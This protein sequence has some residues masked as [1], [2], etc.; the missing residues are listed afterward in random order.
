[1]EIMRKNLCISLALLLLFV[2]GTYSFGA[3]ANSPIVSPINSPIVSPINSPIVSPTATGTDIYGRYSQRGLNRDLF[4]TQNPRRFVPYNSLDNVNGRNGLNRLR[5]ILQRSTASYYSLSP[6]TAAL[7]S[8]DLTALGQTQLPLPGQLPNDPS[9]LDLNPQRP[10]SSQLTDIDMSLSR[11]MKLLELRDLYGDLPLEAGILNEPVRKANPDITDLLQ[12]RRPAE[13]ATPQLPGEPFKQ[14]K[15]LDDIKDGDVYDSLF[16]E[17]ERD[18]SAKQLEEKPGESKYGIKVPKIKPLP[19][20]DHKKAARIRGKHKTFDSLARAKTEDYIKIAN[21]MLTAGKSYKAADA[22]TLAI[23]WRPENAEAHLIKGLALFAAGEYMSAS[24][25]IQQAIELN[26][27]YASEKIGLEEKI[28][29]IDLI[30]NRLVEAKQWQRQARSPEIAF[31]IAF[32]NY[33]QGNVI[34][35]LEIIEKAV[36][37]MGDNAAVKALHEV[38][39]AAD[40]Y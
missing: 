37:K 31:L 25:F 12:K 28:P 17:M 10:M 3:P 39:K 5:S 4:R 30:D 40:K 21:K 7:R 24:F 33:Q 38:I 19:E 20:A 32:I 1:M 6:A 35:A 2:I 22:C 26:K 27:D 15:K 8:S 29:D 11:D 23:V 34:S 14:K 16:D 13:P 36:E 9:F 18:Q